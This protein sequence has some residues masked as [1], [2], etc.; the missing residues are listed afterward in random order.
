[1]DVFRLMI[2]PLV[3]GGGKRFQSLGT[4]DSCT[5]PLETVRPELR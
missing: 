4:F 5:A 2:M 1:V 3:I